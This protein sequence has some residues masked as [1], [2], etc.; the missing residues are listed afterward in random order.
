MTWCPPRVLRSKEVRWKSRSKVRNWRRIP[1]PWRRRS[2]RRLY[3]RNVRTKTCFVIRA[4][5]LYPTLWNR[6]ECILVTAWASMWWPRS[7]AGKSRSLTNVTMKDSTSFQNWWRRALQRHSSR[8]SARTSAAS[9][10]LH[11]GRLSF[12]HR[13][14]FPRQCITK[15]SK[16]AHR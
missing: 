5:W 4:P 11:S 3:N 16:K 6:M 1:L 7:A 14:R 2:L 10:S 15:L 8:R 9:I 12:P 13:A